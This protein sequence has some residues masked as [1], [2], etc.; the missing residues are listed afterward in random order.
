MQIKNE[1]PKGLSNKPGTYAS[2]R[3]SGMLTSMRRMNC[4]NYK[5]LRPAV[6]P[7]YCTAGQMYSHKQPAFTCSDC[8]LAS[9]DSFGILSIYDIYY[10][11]S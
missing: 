7:I 4:T 6:E 9:G 11:R 8:C 2:A 10:I 1:I 5:K 3:L